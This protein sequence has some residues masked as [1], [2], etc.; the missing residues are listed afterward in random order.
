MEEERLRMNPGNFPTFDGD[1][2]KFQLWWCKFKACGY[3][4]GFR[5]AIGE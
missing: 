5:E 1:Q 4:A 3:L 2:S